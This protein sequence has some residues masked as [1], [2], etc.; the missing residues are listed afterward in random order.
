M[1]HISKSFGGVYALKDI[2]FDV[3]KEIHAI[4]GHNGAGKS[5][6]MKILMGA[7]KQDEGEIRLNGQVLNI[8]SP[9]E[10]LKNK[11]AMVW[12]ELANFPNMTVM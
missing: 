5:T 8:S 7:L 10:A 2:D 1:E 11:I 9:R 6:L 4:V 12:Q 3:R